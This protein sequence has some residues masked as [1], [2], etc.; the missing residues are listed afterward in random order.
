VNV[1]SKIYVAGHMGLVGSA[2]IRELKRSGFCNIVVRTREELDLRNQVAV[3]T[4]FKRELPEYV[5]LAAARV[6]GIQANSMFPAQFAYDNLAIA[7]HV[8]DA[9]YRYGVKKLLFLGSSCIYPRLAKQPMCEHYL[10]A[11][12]L[13]STNEPYAVA[14]IAGIKLCQ[15]YNKEYG[16]NYIVAIP[17]NLYGPFDNFDEQTSHV[18]PGLLAKMCQAKKKNLGSVTVWGTG[19]SLREFLY[20]DDLAQ[21]C[22][23]LMHYYDECFPINIGFGA[24]ITIKELAYMIRD[25]VGFQGALVFDTSKPDGTPKKLLDSARIH[26]IGWRA[27]T[28]LREGIEKT[29]QWYLECHM[30][31]MLLK[32]DKTELNKEL[33]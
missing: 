31:E 12:A 9:A 3:D 5:F 33:L 25:V 2:L 17:T 19:R 7:L 13:E 32:D 6:G 21:A 20:V 11:G 26:N 10:L 27:Q 15:A 23:H 22:I 18:V 1:R 30:P 24:D 16:T 28:S 29:L 4:F 8:V 14:K